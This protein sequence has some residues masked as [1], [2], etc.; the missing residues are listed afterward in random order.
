MEGR[1][2]MAIV[3]CASCRAVIPGAYCTCLCHDRQFVESGRGV[4]DDQSGPRPDSTTHHDDGP[5]DATH[6]RD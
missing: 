6:E 2:T 5:T 4:P 3:S 1:L